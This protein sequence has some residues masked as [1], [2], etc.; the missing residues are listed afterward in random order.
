MNLGATFTTAAV[1]A[2]TKKPEAQ[3]RPKEKNYAEGYNNG[4]LPMWSEE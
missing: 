2:L 3:D 4:Q 1:H